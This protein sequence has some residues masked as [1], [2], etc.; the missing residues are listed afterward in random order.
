METWRIPRKDRM[1]D[2]GGGGDSWRTGMGK[3]SK[4]KGGKD[5]KEVL[6]PGANAYKIQK[7]QTREAEIKREVQALLNKICPENKD[8]IID[9]IADIRIEEVEE[10]EVLIKIIFVKVTDDPHYCETYVDMIAALNKKYPEFPPEEEGASPITFRR[11]LVNM[12]QDKFEEMLTKLEEDSEEA[13]ELAKTMEPDELAEITLKR[14]RNAMATMKFIGNLFV[15]QLLAAAV[16]RRVIGDL[17]DN[18]PPEMQVEYA[19]E[20]VAAVGRQFES[21]E[22]DKAQI[23]IILDRLNNLKGMKNSTTGKPLLSKR[24]QF[25]IEDMLVLR[26]NGWVKKGQIKAVKLDAVAAEQTREE[27]AAAQ[28]SRQG[29]RG[30]GYGHGR[31]GRH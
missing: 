14:K 21:T 30:G 28:A 29:A 1:A 19:L 31:A 27:Y 12:C 9:R 6:K 5:S 7:A 15:R 4:A 10:M 25:A 3:S 22:K 18:E 26:T 17:L 24:V 16:I 11:M 8:R 23:S 20:L 13:V 2:K